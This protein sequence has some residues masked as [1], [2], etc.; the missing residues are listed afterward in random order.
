MAF[1]APVAASSAVQAA[2]AGN[3]DLLPPVDLPSLL[4]SGTA[5]DVES[6]RSAVQ[7]TAEQGTAKITRE[8]AS[9]TRL[10]ESALKGIEN[11][12]VRLTEA[13]AIQG[14][15]AHPS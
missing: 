12:N 4:A 8:S 5:Q 14:T 9:K 13:P 10:L 7:Q 6:L 2:I 11:R 3:G 1:A 15:G